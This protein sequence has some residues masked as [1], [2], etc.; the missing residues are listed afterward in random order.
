MLEAFENDPDRPSVRF[1]R[2]R[3]GKWLA[4]LPGLARDRLAA[5]GVVH[6]AG[7]GWCTVSDASR[8]FSFRR[9]RVTGRMLALC[10][11]S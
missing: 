10:W 9:D 5:A 6:V 1:R 4:D 7:G 8:F 2:D 11:R 3:P